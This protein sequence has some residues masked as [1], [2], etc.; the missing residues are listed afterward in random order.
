M[1]L[2]FFFGSL[3]RLFYHGFYCFHAQICFKWF[4]LSLSLCLW[5][6]FLFNCSHLKFIFYHP[7]LLVDICD[8]II[9][10]IIIIM[11]AWTWNMDIWFRPYL[12]SL[13][14]HTN[15]FFFFCWFMQNQPLIC[16]NSIQRQTYRTIIDELLRDIPMLTTDTAEN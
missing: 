10:N 5:F 1:V 9:T 2:L 3:S 11:S 12:C 8:G 14:I 15:T 7:R 6:K 4:S 13:N 16:L